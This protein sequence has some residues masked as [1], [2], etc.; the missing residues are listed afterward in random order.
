MYL[1]KETHHRNDQ[2][3]SMYDGS[4]DRYSSVKVLY[5]DLEYCGFKFELSLGAGSLL[6]ARD[7]CSSRLLLCSVVGE[8]R[9]ILSLLQLIR[10]YFLLFA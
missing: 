8:C 3:S 5:K 9:P 7:E 6:N 1:K 4:G 10:F 2:A